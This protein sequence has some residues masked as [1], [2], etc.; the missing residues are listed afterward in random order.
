ME[1][2][3]FR[4]Y[5]FTAD[6]EALANDCWYSVIGVELEFEESWKNK[7]M[8]KDNDYNVYLY[9]EIQEL[10]EKPKEAKDG[11]GKYHLCNRCLRKNLIPQCLSDNILFAIDVDKKL[12]GADSDVILQCENYAKDFSAE[13]APKKP[14][15]AKEIFVNVY[16]DNSLEIYDTL[17]ESVYRKEWGVIKRLEGV[18]CSEDKFRNNRTGY[19]LKT[20]GDDCSLSLNDEWIIN[21]GDYL[22]GDCKYYL[23]ELR[24]DSEQAP[25]IPQE[26][27]NDYLPPEN[28][29][30]WAEEQVMDF[31][32]FFFSQPLDG[33]VV[34]IDTVKYWLDKYKGFDGIATKQAPEKPKKIEMLDLNTVEFTNERMFEDKINELTEAVNKLIVREK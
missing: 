15:E 19:S 31:A 23:L 13:Q 17:K 26:V 24:Y 32:L 25:E 29:K 2:K 9:S 12:T 16:D 3:K 1:L 28:P 30:N 33:I 22:F 8:L 20:K 21:D 34:D 5:P 14:K 6:T 7:L 18:E 27:L 4:E 10:R 11:I